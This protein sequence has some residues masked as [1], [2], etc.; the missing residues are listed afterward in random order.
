[1]Q[2]I[3]RETNMGFYDD[4][5]DYPRY[6]KYGGYN[7]YDDDTIDDAFEGDPEATWNID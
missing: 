7:G 1:M 2:T 6:D 4:D 5:E 3:K